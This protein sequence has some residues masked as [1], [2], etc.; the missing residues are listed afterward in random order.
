MIMTA[1]VAAVIIVAVWQYFATVR[2]RAA[3]ALEKASRR[4]LAQ[5]LPRLPLDPGERQRA[6]AI[7]E[8]FL[9]DGS[10]IVRVNALEGLAA[11]ARGDGELA[12]KVASQLAAV[13]ASGTPAEKARARKLM[14]GGLGTG[15][16]PGDGTGPDG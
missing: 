9:E 8:G 4:H 5:M 1:I 16:G 7:L 14:R 13:L 11:L 12:A 6:V 10:T 3:D 15:A 2:S